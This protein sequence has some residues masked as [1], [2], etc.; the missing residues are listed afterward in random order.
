MKIT[1][2]EINMNI[3]MWSNLLGVSGL[4]SVKFGASIKKLEQIYQGMS[5]VA[6]PAPEFFGGKW[7]ARTF[8]GGQR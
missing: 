8:L 2:F 7:G 3:I 1:K 4:F 5:T 6:E